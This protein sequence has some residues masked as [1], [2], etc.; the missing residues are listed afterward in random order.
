MNPGHFNTA[1]VQMG[2][3]LPAKPWGFHAGILGLA[4]NFSTVGVVQWIQGKRNKAGI[5]ECARDGSR[6]RLP[7][8]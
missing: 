8:E 3:P 2:L 1:A 6:A 5:F 7:P 4:A